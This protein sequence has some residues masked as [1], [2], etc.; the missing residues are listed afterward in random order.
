M[1]VLHIPD[2]SHSKEGWD[3]EANNRSQGT[4]QVHSLGAFQDGGNP[5]DSNVATRSQLDG[6]IRSEGHILCCSNSPG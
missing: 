6:E 1:A 5:S 3:N 4:K 2:V